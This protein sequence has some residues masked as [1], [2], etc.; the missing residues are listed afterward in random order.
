MALYTIGEVA[1]LCEVNPVT[2]RAWQRRYGLLKPQR[3]D[4]GHRLFNDQDIDRIREI[5][6]W[7]DNG[8]QVSKVKALLSSETQDAHDDGWRERQEA[9]LH[10]LREGSPAQLRHW[11]SDIG[12]DYPAD[13]LVNHLFNPLRRRLQ[14]QQGT[15]LA[16][17]SL[18]DGALINYIA[19]CLNSSRKKPGKDA[20]V[21]GWNVND[22]TRLWLAA[23]VAAQQ[24]WRVDV[25]ANPLSQ[26]RP[27]TFNGR[28]LLVWCGEAPNQQMLVQ[29]ERWREK[30][31]AL[32]PLHELS[33]I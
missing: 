8:V 30:G 6:H 25:L 9:L 29:L 15:L 16:L 21:V 20:L 2:L 22:G 10:L 24:G 27:E 14:C 19:L 11:I 31:H 1:E 17:L 23:W 7:I 3:T 32:I 28:T 33:A 13:A 12:R 18:L 26:L 5:K 4:G